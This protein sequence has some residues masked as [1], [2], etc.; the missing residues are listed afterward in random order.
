MGLSKLALSQSEIIIIALWIPL[1]L[2]CLQEEDEVVVQT[3]EITQQ[4]QHATDEEKL[5]S[6]AI[7]GQTSDSMEQKEPECS[8]LPA[9]IQPIKTAFSVNGTFC[10]VWLRAAAVNSNS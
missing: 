8:K 10:N 9:Q 5:A 4:V 2:L 6:T 1:L 7:M 3:P